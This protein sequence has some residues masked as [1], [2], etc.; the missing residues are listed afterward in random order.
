MRVQ[1]VIRSQGADLIRV[2]RVNLLGLSTEGWTSV[3]P[4]LPLLL[5]EALSGGSEAGEVGGQAFAA[6]GSAPVRKKPCSPLASWA[7]SSASLIGVIL[8]LLGLY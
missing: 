2:I 4:P 8:G 5:I 7:L 3:L 6:A 1:R